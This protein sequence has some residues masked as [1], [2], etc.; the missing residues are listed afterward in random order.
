MSS[1]QT[2][3]IVLGLLLPGCAGS[4]LDR[5]ELRAPAPAAHVEALDPADPHPGAPT[6]D[7]GSAEDLAKKLSNPVASLISV[8]LQLNHDQDIGP[9]EEGERWQLN[10]QPVVPLSLNEEWNVISR[11]ILPV[12]DQNDI[13]PGEDESGLGDITQSLFFSPKQPTSNGLIWGAGP[14]FLIPTATD[15]ALGTEKWGL[16][17]TIVLLKQEGPY[18]IGVLANHIWSVAG[19]DDRASISSSFVQP[20]VSHTTK[21]A[22]TYS[23]N[24]ESTY[25]WHES[26]LALPL[27]LLVS[28]L[29]HF[30]KLPVSLG[31]GG[32]YWVEDSEGGP[33]GLGLRFVLTLLFPE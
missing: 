11:T 16:G 26:D 30:G 7:G 31:V 22:W 25:D 6:A 23:L 13:P 10:L 15:E 17:P 21:T 2:A 27:N 14:V 24:A 4:G 1:M 33:E 3:S 28:K 9:G 12:I 5:R 32:R 20:F 29:T 19:D 18:T 8:P